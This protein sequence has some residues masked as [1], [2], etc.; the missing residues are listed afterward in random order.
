MTRSD[1]PLVVL[2][3][4]Q[5]LYDTTHQIIAQ[6]GYQDSKGWW[7]TPTWGW[8]QT[9]SQYADF[10]ITGYVDLEKGT[11][12]GYSHYFNPHQISLD[13]AESIVKV[14]RKIKRGLDR[15]D[16]E[17]G[18]IPDNSFHEYVIRITAALGITDYRVPT[19]DSPSNSGHDVRQVSGGGLRTWLH[20]RV[21]EIAH[22]AAN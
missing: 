19:G 2:V 16:T 17:R 11:V 1:I 8:C 20:H 9:A 3:T 18:Y 10:Q 15:A 12:W 7:Q 22:L 21:N 6:I 5:H 14:L 13:Q 4:S